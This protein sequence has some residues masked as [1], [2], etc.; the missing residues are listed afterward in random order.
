VS[1][2]LTVKAMIQCAQRMTTANA[3]R[4]SSITSN[5]STTQAGNTLAPNPFAAL[6][7]PTGQNSQTSSGLPPLPGPYMDPYLMQQMAAAFS[8]AGGA[9]VV[10]QQPPEERFHVQLQQL[11]D[12]GFW[13]AT[14]NIRALL[15]TGGEVN[16]AIEYLLR[17]PV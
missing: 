14:Q 1:T 7:N 6:L 5:P 3:A 8:G 16:A 15:A 2:V 10:P 9:P 17:H 4:N 13:D 11:N 12:M